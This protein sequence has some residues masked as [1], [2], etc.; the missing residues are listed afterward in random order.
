MK[1]F[2]LS[3]MVVALVACGGDDPVSYSEPVGLALAAEPGDV[4]DGWIEDSKNINTESANPYG[5]FVAAAHEEVGGEPSHIA[6]TGATL[7]IVGAGGVATLDGIYAGELD[8]S[9]VTNGSETRYLVASLDE[10]PVAAS[11]ELEVFFDSDDMVAADYADLASG[12]FKVVLGGAAAAGFHDAGVKV[13]LSLVLT[14]EA[15][16]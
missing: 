6:V 16:E 15:F 11:A 7:S 12:A 14:F 5:A 1:L 13:D 10:I 9:F 4:S 2:A 3:M 8:V